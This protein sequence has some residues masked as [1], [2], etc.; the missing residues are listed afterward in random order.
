MSLTLI[1]VTATIP[2]YGSL[3]VQAQLNET[4]AQVVQTLRTA[5]ENSVAGYNSSAH[6]VYFDINVGGNDNYILYQG[7]SYSARDT[8]YDRINQ[9]DGTLSFSNIDFN[10][11]STKIDVNF[12]KGL[13]VPNNTGS[14]NLIHDI[15][16]S[17]IINVNSL[18]KVEED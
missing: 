2:I 17:V 5:R 14:L 11:I 4:S 8:S 7:S 12:S 1:L 6:G 10:L 15:K 16:G 9:L 3:Q 18:G 13:G